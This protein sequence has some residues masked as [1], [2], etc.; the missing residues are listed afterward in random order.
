[1]P[2]ITDEDLRDKVQEMD[3]FIRKKYRSII[4]G[5]RGTGVHMSSSFPS[6]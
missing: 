2:R 3:D 6:E 5:I 1:V 4:Q